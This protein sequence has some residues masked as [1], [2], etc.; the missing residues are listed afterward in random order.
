MV[1]QYG[2]GGPGLDETNLRDLPNLKELFRSSLEVHCLRYLRCPLLWISR[3]I[4][5]LSIGILV[6]VS[7]VIIRDDA[8]VSPVPWIV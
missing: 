5:F 6:L 3:M 1:L 2:Q 7:V 4:G 8:L